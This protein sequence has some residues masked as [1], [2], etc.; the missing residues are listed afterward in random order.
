MTGAVMNAPK[1]NVVGTSG[2]DLLEQARKALRGCYVE[3]PS[4]IFRRWELP[5]GTPEEAVIFT[6]DGQVIARYSIEDLLTETRKPLVGP[7][8]ALRPREKY[9]HAVPRIAR[10]TLRRG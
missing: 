6:D 3:T 8:E 5:G 2:E 9:P 4:S 1:W 7:V 10:A